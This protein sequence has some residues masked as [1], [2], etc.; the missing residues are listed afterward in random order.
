MLTSLGCRNK[1]HVKL[2][3]FY[4]LHEKWAKRVRSKDSV[5]LGEINRNDGF[6]GRLVLELSRA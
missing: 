6:N 1:N 2:L 3:Q 4:R 5:G